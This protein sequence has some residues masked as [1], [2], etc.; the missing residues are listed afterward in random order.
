M[1]DFLPEFF[2]IDNLYILEYGDIFE[3]T[4]FL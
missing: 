4:L 2:F 1:T 3:E